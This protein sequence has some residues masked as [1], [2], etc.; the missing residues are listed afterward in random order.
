MTAVEIVMRRTNMS[1][2]DAEFYVSMAEQ[3]VIE[4]LHLSNDADLSSYTFP[5]SDIAVLYWQRDQSNNNITSALGFTTASFSEGSVSE[6]HGVM[7]GAA[8]NEMY[9]SAIIDVLSNLDGSD[10]MVIFL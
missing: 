9:E 4:Y 1:Q 7:T 10:G 3:R 5:V 2:D 6:S 8:V